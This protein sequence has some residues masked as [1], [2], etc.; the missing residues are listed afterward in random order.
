MI[1]VPVLCAALLAGAATL[2]FA[3]TPTASSG[4]RAATQAKP[5]AATHQAS[6]IVKRV[7]APAATLTVTH[8]PVASLNWP[9]MTM[10]FKLREQS[11]AARFK[12]GDKVEFDFQESGGD[13]LITRIAPA[14]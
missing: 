5:A 3:Q 14:R 1:R 13:Y 4:A 8:G 7:N 10:D 12:P 2:A 11:A 9:A 6:G